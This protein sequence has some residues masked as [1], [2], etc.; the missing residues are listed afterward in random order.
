MTHAAKIVSRH[1]LLDKVIEKNTGKAIPTEDTSINV[2][3]EEERLLRYNIAD[4]YL[5][6]KVTYQLPLVYRT[7]AWE[8]LA[9]CSGFA[10]YYI[11]FGIYQYGVADSSG[12]TEDL[13]SIY[14]ASYQA[15]ILTHHF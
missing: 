14:F 11:P 13:F 15:N 6:S 9:I 2:Y 1:P 3:A 5:F 7:L 4:Y 8:V 10:C 12:R